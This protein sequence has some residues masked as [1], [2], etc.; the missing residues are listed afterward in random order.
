MTTPAP[1]HT[2]ATPAVQELREADLAPATVGLEDEPVLLEAVTYMLETGGKRLRPG[3]CL[4]AARY[5]PDA[6]GEAVRNTAAGVELMHAACL[7]HDDIIDHSSVRRGQASLPE[8]LGPT[9]AAVAGA[10]MFGRAVDLIAAS[11][12]DGAPACI[13]AA[14]A[15][16]QGQMMDG[17]DVFLTT[18]TPE[19]Y[20]ETIVAKTASL[21]AAAAELGARAA[22]ADPSTVDRLRD[23]G[24]H[25][26]IVF[27]IT[28]DLLD[29]VGAEDMLNKPRGV[30]LRNGI[31]T[32]PVLYALEADPYLRGLLPY[33]AVDEKALEHIILTVAMCGA[34]ER[35]LDDAKRHAELGREALRSLGSDAGGAGAR[36]EAILDYSLAR[37][38]AG[39]V[40]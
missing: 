25:L 18:R 2:V 6:D 10:W 12:P 9:A 28:D 32:L 16:C 1:G 13:R 3:V 38:A 5:G 19:R 34:S 29:L 8:H 40:R 27:Q 24:H 39:G 36:L 37:A 35:A 30:D 11:C 7:A 31:Y 14:D 33:A 23:Y 26:G 15:L 22:G 21:F 17:E 4:E 20:M